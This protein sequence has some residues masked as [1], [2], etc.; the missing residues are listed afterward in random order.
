MNNKTSK[1]TI[2]SV[3]E[4]WS[5]NSFLSTLFALLVMILIQAAVLCHHYRRHRSFGRLHP[6]RHRCGAALYAR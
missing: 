5:K 2:G 1:R 6:L 3:G 4:I